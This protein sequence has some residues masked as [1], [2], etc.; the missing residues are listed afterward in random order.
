MASAHAWSPLPPGV[1]AHAAVAL[2]PVV[3]DQAPTGVRSLASVVPSLAAETE[4]L[5]GQQAA[6]TEAS[7]V[8]GVAAETTPPTAIEAA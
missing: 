5:Q 6:E 2:A 1:E 8:P 3:P 4:A 7:V